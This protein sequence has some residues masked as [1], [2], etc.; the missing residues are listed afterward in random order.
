[1]DSSNNCRGFGR[2]SRLVVAGAVIFALGMLAGSL[3]STITSIGASSSMS[4]T[5]AFAVFEET[6]NLV[7][8]QYV[9]PEELDDT[10]LMYGAARGMVE[11]VGDVGHSAFLDPVE[12]QS[13]Q[14]ALRG[15]LI[16][17]GVRLEFTGKYPEIV[18]PIAGS[19][20]DAAGIESGDV[21]LAIDGRDTSRLTSTEI[22]T[23]LRGEEGVPVDLTIGR[24]AADI[25]FD[26]SI[27][28][29]KIVVEPVA[30]AHLPDGLF[31]VSLN[32]FSD[33]AADALGEALDIANEG[34]A[35]GI[36]L[37]M[38]GNP[39][40]YVHEAKQVASEF[41]PAGSV[42]YVEQKRDEEPN[43]VEL[44]RESGRARDIPLIV[45]VDETSASAAEIVA[46]SLRDNDRAHVVGVPTFGTATV[47][48]SFD[49][50]D[51]SLA[52]IGTA[53]WTTPDGENARNVGIEPSTIVELPPL[54]SAIQFEDGATIELNEI[55]DAEDTQLLAAI[56]LLRIE[57]TALTGA[58]A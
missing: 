6:W 54:V 17:I 33:G 25:E 39:G 31:L 1:M 27:E 12:A 8:D 48:S 11:A 38:R 57:Q 51:G 2:S 15:E 10:E 50:A 55:Q 26:V 7:H 23:L 19:P 32:E 52:A 44:D 40:G 9:L 47:V 41:L 29:A 36:I 43:A 42:L 16:G 28:R 5:P 30:W 53:V 4:D 49:L 3:T 56:D 21:I 37:D 22:A 20:A 34:G 14:S 46:A 18:E 58:A 24:P 13:F 45:L 35:T